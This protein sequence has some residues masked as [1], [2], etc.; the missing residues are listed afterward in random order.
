MIETTT[1]TGVGAFCFWTLTSEFNREK[2]EAGMEALGYGDYVPGPRDTMTIMRRAMEAVYKKDDD[3]N[4]LLVRPITRGH[5]VVREVQGEDGNDYETIVT[6]KIGKEGLSFSPP[7]AAVDLR[8]AVGRQMGMLDNNQITVMLTNALRA[9]PAT[10]LMRETGGIY[11][12]R[13]E[14]IDLAR[15]MG[16]VVE[17]AALMGRSN[18]YIVRTLMDEDGIRAVRDRVID[19][20]TAEME[21][22]NKEIAKGELGKRGLENRSKQCLAT[23]DNVKAFEAIFQEKLTDLRQLVETTEQAATKAALLA[24]MKE[25]K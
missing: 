21:A 17:E 4:S 15:Q 1:T 20:I 24:Q 9:Q 3:D 13:E 18:V 6:V 12:I 14:T 16:K 25:E 19:T 8:E 22:H 23:L 5:S 11:W 10:Q 2:V 7:E